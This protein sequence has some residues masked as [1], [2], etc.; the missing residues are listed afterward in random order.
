MTERS[1]LTKTS[2]KCPKNKTHRNSD[3]LP[4]STLLIGK[5]F[6]SISG[7][8]N[9]IRGVARGVGEKWCSFINIMMRLAW[10]GQ[11]VNFRLI[12]GGHHAMGENCR[13]IQ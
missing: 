13:L 12:E 3:Q 1:K 9:R 5:C 10:M 8:S 7:F 2:T 6:L 4:L 11:T